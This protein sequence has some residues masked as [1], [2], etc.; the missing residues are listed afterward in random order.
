[1]DTKNR[2]KGFE[3]HLVPCPN[4]KKDILDHM[5][6]CPF[7]RA[8]ISPAAYQPM[9]QDQQRK[10]KLVLAVVLCILAGIMLL[11]VKCGGVI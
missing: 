5:T 8:T 7:C 1:M 2:K 4:C 3:K 11:F 9:S 6:Q 10:I